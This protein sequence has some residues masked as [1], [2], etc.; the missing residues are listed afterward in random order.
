MFI[1]Q[2]VKLDGKLDI[3]NGGVLSDLTVEL[4][5]T[6]KRIKKYKI[7]GVIRIKATKIII[8]LLTCRVNK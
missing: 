2:W 6:T 3:L 8:K 1:F 5:F 4:M 7:Y